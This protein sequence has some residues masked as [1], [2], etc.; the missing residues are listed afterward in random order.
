MMKAQLLMKLNRLFTGVIALGVAIPVFAVTIQEAFD[1]AIKL[2]PTLRSSRFN[3]EA[4][5][6]NIAIARS[7]LLPQISLQGSTNQLTQTTTQDVPGNSSISKSFT[8]PSANHQFVIRQGLLRPKEISAINF[9]ELQSQYGEVKYQ[10]D[11]SELWLRVAYAWIDLVG[12]GQLAEAYKK[13]L[14]S[15]HSA[16]KQESAKFT[17]G[18]GTKDSLVEAEAQYQ[19]AKA[20]YLQAEQTFKARQQTFKLLTQIEFKSLVGKKLNLEPESVFSEKDRDELWK[21]TRD[22]SF[23]LRLVEI[24][25]QL[26]RERVRMARADHLPTLD[27][28]VSWNV[29]RNDATSTQ[30]YQYKNNQIGIQYV[31]PIY[32]G[33]AISATQRQASLALDAS[34][35]DGEAISNR[36]D[37]DFQMLWSAWLGQRARVQAGLKLLESSMEQLRATQLSQIHGVKSVTDV[38]NAELALSRRFGDHINAVIEYHKYSI[39]LSRNHLVFSK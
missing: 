39:R 13:P 11:L 25:Q 33:G 19:F 36:L 15:L 14:A 12:A 18:D 22:K 10:S 4:N 34:I 27:A 35:A 1:N 24:Q 9:A 29:A 30:G 7:R 20:T 23:E 26:Q 2:D 5:N 17:Q 32:T 8:G 16:T 38:A 37:G 6:E 28:L 3:Q 31:V 21:V